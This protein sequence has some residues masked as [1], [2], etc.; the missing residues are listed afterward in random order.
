MWNYLCVKDGI[1]W[2]QKDN[3]QRNK[4]WLVRP[5]IV[6]IKVRVGK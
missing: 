2:Q 4:H 1:K 6:D 5:V 3:N